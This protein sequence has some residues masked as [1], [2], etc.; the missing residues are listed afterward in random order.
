MEKIEHKQL[1]ETIFY[2]K[3]ANGLQVYLLPKTEYNKTYAT[4][5]TN[6]G[7]IDNVFQVAGKDQTVIPDGVAHFLEHKMFEQESGEDVFQE[8]SRQ[9][10]SA[11]A[12]TSFTR[13]SY[14]F[15]CTENVEENLTTLLDYV[16]SPYFTDENV[17]KEKGIIGQE[18]EMY[19]DNPDW[20]SYFGLIEA[21]YQYHPVKIDI[22]GTIES[23]AKITKET[24]Y[25]CYHSFYHPSNMIL[26]VVGAIS[27]ESMM[28]QIKQNQEKK[29]FDIQRDVHRYF[30]KEPDQ[31]SQKRKEIRLSVG[32][33]KCLFGFKEK[34]IALN[35]TGRALLKQELATEIVLEVLLGT[36]SELYQKLY[37]EGLIDDG[38][39][40]DYALEKNYGF[41]LI[42]GDTQDPDTLLK[43]IED[44]IPAMV[45]DGIS[46]KEFERTRKKKIGSYLKAF[47]SPEWIANQ[48][49]SYQFKDTDVFQIIPILEELHIDDVNH[50]MKEHFDWNQFA[51]SVVLSKE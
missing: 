23:I 51:S 21:M 7:S 22:A 9:G 50:R 28:Q 49:T 44:E 6:Y 15:S 19:D 42:G 29:T 45:R 40:S 13:T 26:F 8:F 3:Q 12:F 41:T 14:L 47:N 27:P 35:K 36:S 48:F 43:R 4:F 5:T 17:E 30:M 16:Q 38:F 34:N 10:A 31:V 2:E 20:R 46:E 11:N 33:P 1:Q 24:L 37:D 32:I 25:T 18:I 39:G